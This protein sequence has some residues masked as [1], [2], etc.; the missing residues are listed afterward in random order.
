MCRSFLANLRGLAS[1]QGTHCAVKE[2]QQE[3]WMMH[4]AVRSGR[5]TLS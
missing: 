3:P 5:L 4:F 2:I 1:S